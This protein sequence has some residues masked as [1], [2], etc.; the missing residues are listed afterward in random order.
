MND[1]GRTLKD[2]CPKHNEVYLD[3]TVTGGQ[4]IKQCTVKGCDYK[5]EYPDMRKHA[6]KVANDRR[7]QKYL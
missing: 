2:G 3:I 6:R 7:V 4:V 1:E 5:T